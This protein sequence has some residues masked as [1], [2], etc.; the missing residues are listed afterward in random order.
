MSMTSALKK[1]RASSRN[2]DDSDWLVLTELT[3]IQSDI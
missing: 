1:T 2:V 3:D